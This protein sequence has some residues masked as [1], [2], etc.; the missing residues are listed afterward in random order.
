MINKS[1]GSSGTDPVHS[2]LQTVTEKGYLGIFSTQ[3][4]GHICLGSKFFNGLIAGNY[5][6]N[7]LNPQPG[8]DRKP[9]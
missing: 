2:L 8:R 5:F 9:C 1:A 6:L 7:M 3:F 4:N